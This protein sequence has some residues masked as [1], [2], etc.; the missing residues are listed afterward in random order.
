MK[1]VLPGGTGQVGNVLARA[2]LAFP[3]WPQ[4]AR[5]LVERWKA[6]R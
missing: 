1:I 3:E 6:N 2:F 5:N 4:A